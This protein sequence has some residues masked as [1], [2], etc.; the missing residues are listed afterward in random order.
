MS[1]PKPYYQDESCTIYN[2]DCREVL[3]LL[4]KVDLVLTDP[5]YRQSFHEGNGL[6]KGSRAKTYKQIRETVG[7]SPD[8]DITKFIPLLKR[9]S[10]NLL[11]WCSCKQLQELIALAGSRFNI[12]VWVKSNPIPLV[13]NK[14][15]NDTEFCVCILDD[16]FKYPN[17][18]PFDLKRTAVVLKNGQENSIDHPTVKPINLIQRNI[19]CFSNQK[20][21]ILDPFMGSGTTL[22]AA[23]DLNRKAIGIEIEE[24]YCE[25][26]A[27]RL[28]QE[29]FQFGESA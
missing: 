25:I 22:R 2:A 7:S 28:Q 12:L 13:K 8:F 6:I 10:S 3:P 1:L 4:P 29:V 15:L 14:L 24:K 17:D 19:K 21:T 16:K 5:P 26:A 18:I 27:R 9:V 23:K 11:I 20:E